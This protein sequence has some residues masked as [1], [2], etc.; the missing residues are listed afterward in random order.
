MRGNSLGYFGTCRKP[1]EP[2]QSWVFHQRDVDVDSLKIDGSTAFERNSCLRHL[3][4]LSCQPK[5]VLCFHCQSAQGSWRILEQHSDQR[6][7]INNLEATPFQTCQPLMEVFNRPG[8]NLEW[9]D[10]DDSVRDSI[11]VGAWVASLFRH[12]LAELI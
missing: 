10:E 1:C 11:D 2:F 4:N 7:A 12:R 5:T 9:R 8:W 6:P 3:S